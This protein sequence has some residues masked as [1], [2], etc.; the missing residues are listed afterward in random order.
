MQLATQEDF[1]AFKGADPWQQSI[2][3]SP[4]KSTAIPPS[5]IR[6][7]RHQ[8]ELSDPESLKDV[9]RLLKLDPGNTELLEQKQ[10]FWPRRPASAE[11]LD[12][13]RQAAQNADAAL[14]R[15]KEYRPNTSL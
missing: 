9:E 11:K 10:R 6:P 8:Q 15:G 12:T 1:D 2:K 5:W 4:W 7:W 14:Q 13:L 3:A